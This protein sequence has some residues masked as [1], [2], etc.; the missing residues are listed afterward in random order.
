MDKGRDRALGS[1]GHCG[2]KGLASRRVESSSGRARPQSGARDRC[3]L[4]FAFIVCDHSSLGI[5][6]TEG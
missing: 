4:L 2:F 5:S 1:W 6:R 3:A